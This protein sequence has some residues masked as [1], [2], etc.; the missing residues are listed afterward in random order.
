MVVMVMAVVIV[1]VV[2]VM[3]MVIM[4]MIVFVLFTLR[5]FCDH[6]FK[7]FA[8]DETFGYGKGLECRQPALI[9]A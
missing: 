5:L 2:M 1:T 4:T 8:R 7:F 3:M 9:V 6:Q